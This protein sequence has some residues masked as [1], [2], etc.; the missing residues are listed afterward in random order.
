MRV[1]DYTATVGAA[2]M[3]NDAGA[4]RASVYAFAYTQ[5]KAAK[6]RAQKP[7]QE[8]DQRP[9]VFCF[10]GGPGSSTLYLHYGGFGPV[11]AVIPGPEG[12]PQGK[13][14]FKPNVDSL[15]DVADLVF[16]DPPGTGFARMLSSDP[17]DSALG[18][19]ADADLMAAFIRRW[20]STH[21]RWGSPVYL[22]GQ[23]YGALRVV[24]V[25]RELLGSVGAG[26]LRA[27]AVDGLILLGQA[28]TL[29]PM[30]TELRHSWMLPTMAALAWEHRKVPRRGRSVTQVLREAHGYALTRLAPAL[31]QGSALAAPERQTIADELSG[32]T[33][34]PAARW[35]EV[36]LRMEAKAYAEA[37]LRED[38]DLIS[39]YD[40]RYTQTMP[41]HALDPVADDPMLSQAA[42]ACHAALQ[43]QLH[44][45][46]R[47]PVSDDYL[48]INF[49]LNA[50]WDWRH[51]EPG[52]PALTDF[53]SALASS[54]HRNPRLRLFVGSGAF[55]LVTPWGAAEHLV[56]RPEIPRDRV[57]HHAYA[58]GHS[59]Y[60]GDEP[61]A[62]LAADLRAFIASG[63][64][65]PA[66]KPVLGPAAV[67]TIGRA[68]AGTHKVQRP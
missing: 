5:R 4:P 66:T 12:G 38:A 1:I 60:L 3:C 62:A 31:L 59:P 33:G 20:L 46:L 35:L 18:L 53:T 49:K 41:A 13:C 19:K 6:T 43:A 52:S 61:R 51:S 44:G 15:L 58:A 11:R 10:N 29:G 9:V 30:H 42:V 14:T 26:Q 56:T 25:A 40:G 22:M 37:L 50:A 45:P 64:A 48:A 54:L 32:L 34:L 68:T 23:S 47:C 55:D 36:G 28:V 16:V 63:A 17:A 24:A 2:V 57:Q 8:S 65:A 7:V 39:Q 21:G 67:S 27:A